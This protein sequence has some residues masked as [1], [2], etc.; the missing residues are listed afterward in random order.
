LQHEVNTLLEQA[1]GADQTK[2]DSQKL[3]PA[4]ARRIALRKQMGQACARLK[5][6]AKAQ[7]EAVKAESRSLLAA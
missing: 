6:R 1:E 3:P 5:A 4:I 2:D 7:A